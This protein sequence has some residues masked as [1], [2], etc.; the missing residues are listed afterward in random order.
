[1]A[2]SESDGK[3][4]LKSLVPATAMVAIFML[5]CI[6]ILVLLNGPGTHANLHP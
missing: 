5:A 1:M 2:N 6:I 4:T 3:K